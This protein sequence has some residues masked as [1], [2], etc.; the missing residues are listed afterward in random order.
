[1]PRPAHGALANLRAYVER[2]GT[3]DSDLV[4]VQI[5]SRDLVSP[6]ST[7][8]GVGRHPGKPNQQPLLALQELWSRYLWLRYLRPSLSLLALSHQSTPQEK[9]GSSEQ[10]A[11]NMVSLRH[12][13]DTLRAASQPTLV[14]HNPTRYEFD[15]SKTGERASYRQH[16]KNML[17]SLQV[18]AVM[19]RNRWQG[20]SDVSSYYRDYIHFNE[21][22][23]ARL[24]E[25]L[26]SFVQQRWDACSL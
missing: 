12:L 15:P 25:D 8:E 5:G 4:V 14:I 1:M 26:W 11:Q 6:K 21:K 3:F 18:P 16:F 13:L 2:F 19:L 24:A 20:R 17:D 10:F 23:N 22:G 7:S 9:T